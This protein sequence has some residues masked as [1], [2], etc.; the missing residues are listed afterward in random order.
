MI[1]TVFVLVVGT[2]AISM[3]VAAI[4]LNIRIDRRW[5]RMAAQHAADRALRRWYS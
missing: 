2:L 5:N 1:F 4:I 3:S